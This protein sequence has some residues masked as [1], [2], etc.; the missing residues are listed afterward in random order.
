[1]TIS[2]VNSALTSAAQS[3]GNRFFLPGAKE[4]AGSLNLGQILKGKVLRQYDSNR[5]L[6]NFDG[7]ER[8]VDSAVP[9]RTG[10]LL[11]GRVIAVGERVEMQ[12]VYAEENNAAVLERNEIGA[13]LRGFS[14][15]RH[16]VELDATLE[17]FQARL[18]ESDRATLLRA[19]RAASDVPAMAQV[20]VFFNKL[21][22]NQSAALLEALY[23]R[24]KGNANPVRTYNE[25]LV[26]P[27][28]EA[29][30][31]QAAGL[32]A[33]T[34]RQLADVISRAVGSE[35]ES[36]DDRR[37]DAESAPAHELPCDGE[38]KAVPTVG[39]APER[40]DGESL[41]RLAQWV[42]NA[43]T[44]GSVVHRL[45]TLPLLLGG[46]LVEVDVA[47]FEQRRE[48][49]Q[50][51]AVQHRQL[52]FTLQT[53]HLGRVEVVARVVGE[54]VRVSIVTE[55]EANTTLAAAH[56]GALK[57]SL[58]EAGWI[59]DELS[60]E[61]RTVNAQTGAVTSV[62]EHVISLDSMNRLI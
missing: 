6:V 33:A 15:S 54:R 44:G 55:N 18:S 27:R 39:F 34:V 24:I 37:A 56:A 60:Y 2:Q 45:G 53:E 5:Y 38:S 35:I 11:H 40:D 21:G 52:V 23:A 7:Q 43:Q 25:W 3:A 32:Q 58:V 62:V 50:Q 22:L 17:R 20:G 26:P 42:L 49:A 61:T 59:T 1:M 28:L 41:N 4:F 8:V 13:G 48:A 14:V 19:M 12:R 30:A 9:L 57:A 36:G 31:G 51:P 10:E 47:L 16:E 46:R 29:L